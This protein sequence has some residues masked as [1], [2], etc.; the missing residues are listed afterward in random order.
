[1]KKLINN[2]FLTIIVILQF[3]YLLMFY[4]K[5]QLYLKSP[6]S[7]I[8]KTVFQIL[9]TYDKVANIMLIMLACIV[10][11]YCGYVLLKVKEKQ[12]IIYDLVIMVILFI[13]G[14]IFYLVF[15]KNIYYNI[16]INLLVFIG[17]VVIV[18]LITL[19]KI[20]NHML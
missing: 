5:N 10:M 19:F 3:G 20:R 15:L 18:L 8:S 17:V 16:L 6:A 1:M 7:S 2:T 12:I 11:F 9:Q 14:L 13:A 4:L